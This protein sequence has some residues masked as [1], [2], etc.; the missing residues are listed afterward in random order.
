[1]SDQCSL[2]F[3]LNDSLIGES[4]Q[5]KDSLVTLIL[6]KLGGQ[7]AGAGGTSPRSCLLSNFGEQS[8]P[9]ELISAQCDGDEKKKSTL[10]F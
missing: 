8:L 3:C 1:M 2:L 6:F 5:Q 4:L 9:S 7:L 10:C